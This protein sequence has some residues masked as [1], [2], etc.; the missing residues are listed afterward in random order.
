LFWLAV[1]GIVLIVATG[2]YGA[3]RRRGRASLR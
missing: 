1:V 2:A 3:I